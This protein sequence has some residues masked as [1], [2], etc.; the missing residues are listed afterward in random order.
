MRPGPKRWVWGLVTEVVA[1]SRLLDRT[2]EVA[3]Q[4][5]EVAAPVMQGLKAI[6]V[7]G[8]AAIVDPALAAEQTIAAAGHTDG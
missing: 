1:H 7:A 5:C 2:V 6:Y 3:T 4:I 8:A